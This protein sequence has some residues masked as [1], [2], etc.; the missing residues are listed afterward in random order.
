MGKNIQS[1]NGDK[2]VF[3]TAEIDNVSVTDNQSIEDNGMHEQ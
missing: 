3:W 2:I 1:L